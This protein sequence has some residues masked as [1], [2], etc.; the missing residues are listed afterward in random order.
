M[1]T[2]PA[3]KHI[4]LEK[5]SLQLNTNR[6]LRVTYSKG[7]K[8]DLATVHQIKEA[9]LTIVPDGKIFF[10]IDASL[11][12]G[13][14]KEAYQ[15]LQELEEWERIGGFAILTY[16]LMA[17]I[18]GNFSIKLYPVRFPKKLFDKELAALEWLEML[19]TN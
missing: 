16:S 10:L 6:I 8:I 13:V 1:T 12:S 17:R 3:D 2:T 7:V 9:G 14:T 15:Y 18:M 5:F 4:Q 11:A 19:R